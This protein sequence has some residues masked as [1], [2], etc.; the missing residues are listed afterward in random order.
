MI[1]ISFRILLFIYLIIAVPTSLQYENPPSQDQDLA[2]TAVQ[3]KCSTG[4]SYPQ[5]TITW[6]YS[7]VYLNI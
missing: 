6:Y 1:V 3:L 5:P 4:C 2:V 7:E